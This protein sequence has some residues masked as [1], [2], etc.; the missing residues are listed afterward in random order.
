MGVLVPAVILI[1][2]SFVACELSPE[3][4]NKIFSDYLVKKLK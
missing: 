2:L 3:Q 1:A 4:E